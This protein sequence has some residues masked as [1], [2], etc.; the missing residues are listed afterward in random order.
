M[1]KLEMY[2]N[3]QYIQLFIE[4]LQCHIRYFQLS[5]IEMRNDSTFIYQGTMMPPSTNLHL[6]I[7]NVCPPHTPQT[8]FPACKFY[9]V[10]KF[11][12]SP[13]ICIFV[14]N[15]QSCT[16]CS[17]D[18]I[19]QAFVFAIEESYAQ[20]AESAIETYLLLYAT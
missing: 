15:L 18:D 3:I 16:Q 17:L 2:S 8:F 6:P 7:C 20:L 9:S 11:C 1:I 13:S 19:E 10:D 4:T 14:R 12:S 5:I